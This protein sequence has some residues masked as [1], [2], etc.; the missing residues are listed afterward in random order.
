MPL[1]LPVAASWVCTTLQHMESWKLRETGTE[2][3]S[4]TERWTLFRRGGHVKNG[5]FQGTTAYREK[6]YITVWRIGSRYMP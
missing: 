2:N 6:F 3:R 1:L 5:H 4:G